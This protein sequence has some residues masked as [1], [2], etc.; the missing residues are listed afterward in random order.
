MQNWDNNQSKENF[1]QEGNFN[2]PGQPQ[3]SAEVSSS[4]ENR[5]LKRS[6]FKG[7]V[8]G[9][10]MKWGVILAMVPMFLTLLMIIIVGNIVGKGP[11]LNLLMLIFL[12]TLVF[13]VVVQW[14]LVVRRLHDINKSGWY[15][16]LFMSF[17]F[18][19]WYLVI[20][21]GNPEVNKYGPPPVSV[22]DLG[23]KGLIK[24][25]FRGSRM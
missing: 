24:E 7:R 13:G 11:F 15:F 17:P 12:L 3:Q 1:Y 8:T 18:M 20:K 16:I 2:S 10:V 21:R 23:I 14:S 19:L 5:E 22:K 25:V 4:L 9:R 6:L